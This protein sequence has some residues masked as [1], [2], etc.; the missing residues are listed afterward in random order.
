MA[1]LTALVRKELC[2]PD[3]ARLQGGDAFRFRHL[4]DPDAD[5]KRFK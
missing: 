2:G 1:P 3:R 5:L 4:L